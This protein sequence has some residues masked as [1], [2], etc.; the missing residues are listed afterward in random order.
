MPSSRSLLVAVGL[1]AALVSIRLVALPARALASTNQIAIIEDD[2]HMLSDPVDTLAVLRKLGARVVRVNLTWSSVAP[3]PRSTQRPSFNAADP[4]AYPASGWAAFD[5]IDIAAKKAGIQVD[6]IISGGAP[7]W[8]EN[9]SQIAPPKPNPPGPLY[10]P[11]F[12]WFPSA[13]QY[14]LFARAVGTR[15]N[16]KYVPNG[17]TT[18]LPRVSF[19]TIFNE[20]NF[21]EDLGPQAIDGSTVPTAPG[22]YRQ[23]V[24]AGWSALQATGHSTKTDTILIGELA[25]RG[26]SATKPRSQILGGLP[27]AY[28]QTKPLLFIQM[29]YCVNSSYQELRG[30]AASLVGCPTTAA[31]SRAFRRSNPGLFQ[32]SGFGAHPYPLAEGQSLPPT[33]DGPHGDPDYTAFSQLPNLWHALDRL[34]AMY[35]SG[36]HFKIYNDEYGYIT[37]PPHPPD[38]IGRFVSPATAAYYIN[39]AEYLS[40]KWPRVVSYMQYPVWDA[41]PNP[42]PYQGFSAGLMTAAG[43]PKPAF[44]SYRLPLFLPVTSTRSGRALEV[45]GGVRPAYFASLDTSTAQ[46]V[47]VQFQAH[48]RGSFTALGAPLKITNRQGYFDVHVK[49]P[50]S[51]TVRLAWAYP[52]LDPNFLAGAAG[53]TVYSRTVQVTVK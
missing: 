6:F 52:K 3:N 16:G 49:F 24:D 43:A 7:R 32:A 48:S 17:S 4:G 14:G 22:M 19:W 13:S 31:G 8:A 36:T 50:T 35:G 53:V 5:N 23:L 41:G 9:W 34:N 20:P 42:G 11:T 25:A 15:Y 28:S 45:W 18:P 46:F 51:G 10:N 47:Q 38:S 27:G 21:G 44:Y 26:L 2:P 12:A 29:L 33:T 30:R 1:A 39:W 37:E 40:Y